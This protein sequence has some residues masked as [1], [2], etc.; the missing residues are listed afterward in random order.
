ML[1]VEIIG[2]T[3]FLEKE[4]NSKHKKEIVSII[5]FENIQPIKNL[6]MISF[7]ELCANIP[8]LKTISDPL[9]SKIFEI[10][11]VY[12]KKYN[13]IKVVVK[14]TTKTLEINTPVLEIGL[15]KY[16]LNV[17]FEYSPE[18]ISDGTIVDKNCI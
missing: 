15:V 1:I 3:L 2:V 11:I 9:P 5:I 18:I 4:E 13:I 14:T 12:M 10:K 8:S 16:N 7:E 17:P 6:Y